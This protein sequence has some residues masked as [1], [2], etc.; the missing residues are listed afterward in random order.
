MGGRQLLNCFSTLDHITQRSDESVGDF[1][2]RYIKDLA[3]DDQVIIGGETIH[4]FVRALG[5]RGSAM[6]DNLS[7]IPIIPI[8]II[9]EML[10]RVKSY[11][12]LEI[13]KKGNKVHKDSKKGI[14]EG[15]HLK[16]R[17]HKIHQEDKR[18]PLVSDPN[19]E[20]YETHTPLNQEILAIRSEIEN[21]D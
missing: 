2:T 17:P 18:R 8:T 12:N 7:V 14:H 13:T 3:S 21:S 5:V 16:Q 11:T 4:A 6:Y 10:A 9:E 19:M 1:Y 15:K 20:V